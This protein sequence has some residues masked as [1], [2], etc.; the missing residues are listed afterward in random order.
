MKYAAAVLLVLVAMVVIAAGPK[1]DELRSA[2][3]QFSNN[4]V[5]TIY[6]KFCPEP[7]KFVAGMMNLGQ[8]LIVVN[9]D[10]LFYY[11]P[12][13]SVAYF[14]AVRASTT[15]GVRVQDGRLEVGVVTTTTEA[16]TT[17]VQGPT[18]RPG[19]G[20]LFIGKKKKK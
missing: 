17:P 15:V 3:S 14:T 6:Y 8:E 19:L 2:L 11:I 9:N 1:D 5:I 16:V 20:D 10:G 12:Y 13:D 7:V 4:D 18:H